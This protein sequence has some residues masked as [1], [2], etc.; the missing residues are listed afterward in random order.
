MA[1]WSGHKQEGR[2]SDGFTSLICLHIPLCLIY[3]VEEGVGLGTR[4]HSSDLAL[5]AQRHTA[6]GRRE[7]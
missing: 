2:G 6:L 7:M 1:A 4:I 3:P 5:E